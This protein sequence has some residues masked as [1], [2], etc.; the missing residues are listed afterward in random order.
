MNADLRE[1]DSIP[2]LPVDRGEQR[3]E[4]QDLGLGQIWT[5]WAIKLPD[6]KYWHEPVA[7]A[8][9]AATEGP[10][11]YRTE[12]D[13]NRMRNNIARAVSDIYGAVGYAPT[14]VPFVMSES[15]GAQA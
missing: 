5:G 1:H 11:L 13:A 10:A 9:E 8:T 6:G 15:K 3:A 14:V 7:D 12:T 4:D 2:Y